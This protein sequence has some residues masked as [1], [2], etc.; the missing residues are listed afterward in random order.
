VAGGSGALEFSVMR[1]ER[2]LRLQIKCWNET[3]NTALEVQSA[4]WARINRP[5]VWA[6]HMMFAVEGKKWIA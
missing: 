3:A 6:P 5:Y 2:K 1:Y 4:S